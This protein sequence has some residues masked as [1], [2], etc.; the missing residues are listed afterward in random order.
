MAQAEKG[1]D[2]YEHWRAKGLSRR[3]KDGSFYDPAIDDRAFAGTEFAE[4]WFKNKGAEVA[5][6]FRSIRESKGDDGYDL[7]VDG[8]TCDVK[9]MDRKNGRLIVKP[10]DVGSKGWP[11]YFALVNGNQEKGFHM[12]GVISSRSFKKKMKTENLGYN[13]VFTVWDHELTPRWLS[14][15]TRRKIKSDAESAHD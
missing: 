7:V 3:R 15:H 10:T 2:L 6:P 13:D 14:S 4:Q 1:S 9:S 12:V 11:D 8:K 5:S